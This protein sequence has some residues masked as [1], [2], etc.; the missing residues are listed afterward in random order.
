[1]LDPEVEHVLR[2]LGY[3]VASHVMCRASIGKRSG[4]YEETLTADIRDIFELYD[5]C[6]PY[7]SSVGSSSRMQVSA[8]DLT[9]A[10]ESRLGADFIIVMRGQDDDGAGSH[11]EVR[12]VVCVQAKRQDF[13]AK[14]LK[15]AASSNHIE[16][17]KSMVRAVGIDN[18]YFAFY[19]SDKVIPAAPSVA[20][21]LAPHSRPS[22]FYLF[23][24]PTPTSQLYV[25]NHPWLRRHPPAFLEVSGYRSVALMRKAAS[26]LP[27][28]EWGVALLNA[29]YFVDSTGMVVKNSGLPSVQHVLM[30]GLNLPDFLL[31]LAECHQAEN[32]PD[33]L[34]FRK[35]V[36]AALSLSTSGQQESLEFAPSFMV[37]VEFD[38]RRGQSRN[39]WGFI[40]DQISELIPQPPAG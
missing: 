29:D 36:S 2:V 40:A 18:A 35:R 24:A 27:D 23:P 11:R 33:D 1:M 30:N 4:A 16:K 10:E 17:A 6:T 21:P 20:W 19:H 26:E 22:L 37:F 5:V 3:V 9:K 25:S 31:E 14:S 28:Y 39:E 32:L 15:Y 13:S 38:S 7:L 12:K 8:H 34:A